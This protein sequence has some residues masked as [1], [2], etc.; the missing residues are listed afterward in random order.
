VLALLALVL[1]VVPGV[2]WMW[3]VYRTDVYEPEPPRHVLSTFLLGVASILPAFFAERLAGL[4]WPFLDAIERAAVAAAGEPGEPWTLLIA[5]FVVIGPAE[6]L[7]KFAAVRLHMFRHREFDE[8][9]DGIIYASAAAL[10]FASVENVF[11]VID[12]SDG[13]GIRWSALGLRSFLALPGH[14]VFAA[15]WGHALGR[16]KF[17]SAYPVWSRVA[18]A[19]ALHGL[20]DFVLI[21]PPSRPLIVLYMSILVPV[22]WRLIVNARED[23]PH[24]PSDDKPAS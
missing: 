5:C 3:I 2:A 20:Y 22:V 15:V 13:I 1:P 23:S 6:E 9:L 18:L 14:V 7:A 16:R 21:Y 8:P 17:D 24:R 19:S 12:F 10:G 11:Y 4:A